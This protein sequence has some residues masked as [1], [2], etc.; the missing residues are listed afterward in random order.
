MKLRTFK[1]LRLDLGLSQMNL[2]K[3][4]GVSRYRIHLYENGF[5]DFT[6]E[7]KEKIGV[8]I[9]EESNKAEREKESRNGRF[10]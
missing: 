4:S 2:S 6:N 5:I 8:A 3:K 7:E 1:A 10:N 9:G